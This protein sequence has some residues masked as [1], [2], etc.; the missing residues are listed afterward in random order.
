MDSRAQ[1]PNRGDL[2]GGGKQINDVQVNRTRQTLHVVNSDV[3][4]ETLD[5]THIGSVESRP[6]GQLFLR[7]TTLNPRCAKSP[8]KSHTR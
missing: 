6:G 8:C 1:L 4:F 7:K 5:G 2:L 3:P